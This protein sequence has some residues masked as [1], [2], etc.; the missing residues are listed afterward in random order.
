MG[1]FLFV[2]VLV[3]ISTNCC[4]L[5]EEESSLQVAFLQPPPPTSLPTNPIP[6][7]VITFFLPAG[8]L[9]FLFSDPF[10]RASPLTY[11]HSQT[12]GQ[13]RAYATATSTRDQSRTCDLH[14]SSQQRQILN[15]LS[16]ARDPTCILMDT[17]RIL[18]RCTTTGIP[19]VSQF[20]TG[21][22]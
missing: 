15:P 20:K 4:R 3:M 1:A 22:H 13:I 21:T 6:Y 19:G 10:F 12:R 5:W 14:H 7:D 16:E 17:S 18:V 9:E 11:G 8:T 2:T